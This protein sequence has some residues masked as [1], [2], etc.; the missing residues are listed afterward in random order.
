MKTRF[1]PVLIAI[2]LVTLTM[3]AANAQTQAALNIGKMTTRNNVD[4]SVLVNSVGVVVLSSPSHS[5]YLDRRLARTLED[6]L[7]AIIGGMQD[8]ETKDTAVVDFR[9]IGRLDYGVANG[10]TTDGLV[11]RLELNPTKNDKVLL[12]LYSTAE[13]E[14]LLFSTAGVAQLDD[15]LI[16]ALKYVDDVSG[17]SGYV[18]SVVEKMRS[19]VVMNNK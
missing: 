3:Y 2:A 18:L 8:L 17:Q 6:N 10:P 14:D 13:K 15:I 4:L 1:Y 7:A 19:T 5:I 16:K 11:F 9:T 12:L